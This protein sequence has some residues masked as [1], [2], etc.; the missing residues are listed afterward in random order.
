M[1][2]ASGNLLPRAP[3]MPLAIGGF[4]GSPLAKRHSGD[5]VLPPEVFVA[6]QVRIA[7]PY[8]E[9][10]RAAL[11]S[12]C[13]AMTIRPM[14]RPRKQSGPGRPRKSETRL[15]RWLDSVGMTRDELAEHLDIHR[16]YVDKICR[17]VRRPSLELALAIEQLSRGSVPAASWMNVPKHSRD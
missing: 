10:V 3:R 4:P 7:S 5:P 1:R 12:R 11:T 9:A 13:A 2:L 8:N 14:G 15:S 17:G 6:R 16:T